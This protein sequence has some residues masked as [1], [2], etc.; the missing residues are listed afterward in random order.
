MEMNILIALNGHVNKHRTCIFDPFRERTIV[1]HLRSVV[2]PAPASSAFGPC[3]DPR[4]SPR[5]LPITPWISA[6][7]AMGALCTWWRVAIVLR[8]PSDH[9]HTFAKSNS[10]CLAL[11]TPLVRV[12]LFSGCLFALPD[13]RGVVEYRIYSSHGVAHAY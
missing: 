8:A 13:G 1:N 6:V 11:P 10:T 3:D 12:F 4:C 7:S 5:Q 2:L 9:V